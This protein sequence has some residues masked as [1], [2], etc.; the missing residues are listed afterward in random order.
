M[1]MNS[2]GVI[3]PQFQ[4]AGPAAAVAR[5]Q[6]DSTHSVTAN[7]ATEAISHIAPSPGTPGPKCATASVISSSA[8][9]GMAAKKAWRTGCCRSSR[10][11]A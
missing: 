1:G 11:A 4:A 7:C 9:I 2:A 5:S 3:P 10:T 6:R 8:E